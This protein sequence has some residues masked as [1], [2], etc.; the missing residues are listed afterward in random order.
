M[1]SRAD[2]EKPSR[3]QPT[4]FAVSLVALI[5]LVALAAM[6]WRAPS[7][8]SQRVVAPAGSATP[9]GA[10]AEA[11]PSATPLSDA[12]PSVYIPGMPSCTCVPA[13]GAA[14]DTPAAA[15]P[16]S[17]MPAQ[18]TSTPLAT[19]PPSGAVFGL[20]WF[21]KPP[22]IPA[23]KVAAEHRYIHLTGRAD[24]PYRDELRAAGYKGPIYSYVAAATVGGPGPY[25][26]SSDKCDA[27]YEP[28]DN[29][30]AWDK[31]DFCRDIH[32]HESWFLHNGKGERL[33]ADYFGKGHWGYL[34]NPADPGWQA[35]SYRRLQYVRD[36]WKYDGIWLDNL[37]LTL[38]RGKS[39]MKNSD[40]TVR[41]YADDD[42]WRTVMQ[43]WLAGLRSHLGGYPI[44]ANLVYGEINA[45][46]WD[47]YAPYLDGA[48]D[49]SFAVRWLDGWR[50]TAEWKGELERS[51]KWLA[52]GKGLV[53]VGQGPKSDQQ[54]MRFTLASYMLVASGQGAFFRYTR[55]DSYYDQLWL[56]P[57][58]S[59]ARALGAPTGE[60]VDVSANLWRRQFANGYAEVD[61]VAHTGR[62]VLEKP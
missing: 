3:G 2:I 12:S 18:A 53:M 23:S 37:D 16:T 7:P 26:S 32:P 27:T 46:G 9:A 41:E 45:G 38:G 40:G 33:V 60:R 19:L 15:E 34:M 43:A 11:L 61:A 22:D 1:A 58:F 10:P 55:F 56:Y 35:Y 59:T 14:G 28:H 17:T 49:E 21:H 36:G 20:A 4:L 50:D 31:G 24:L 5:A 8:L 44:W 54:R 48:M 51:A 52:A 62:L 13:P 29:T 25:T 39:E 6:L 30:V 57:E 42:A 47:A